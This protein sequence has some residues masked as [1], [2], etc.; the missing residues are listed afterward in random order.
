MIAA[1]G[2]AM[3][4]DPNAGVLLIIRKPRTELSHCV[5]RIEQSANFWRLRNLSWLPR[6]GI[7]VRGR[8]Q[9]SGIERRFMLNATVIVVLILALIGAIPTWPHSRRWGLYPTGGI[10]LVLAVVVA[11]LFV[12][13]M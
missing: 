11:L 8:V 3:Q 5:S 2:A 7:N 13:A 1:D 4:I 6:Q 10:G 9:R 12:G